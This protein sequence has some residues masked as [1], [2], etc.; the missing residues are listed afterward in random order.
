MYLSLDNI[1]VFN[2]EKRKN[3]QLPVQ[4]TEGS[5]NKGIIT[6]KSNLN[7]EQALED[8]DGFD[9]I[10][11]IFWFHENTTWR[12]KVLPPRY[13]KKI[14]VFATRSPHRP[15]PIGMSCVKLSKIE[16]RTLFIEDHDL[17]DG[18]P[19]Y[20]IKPYIA[21][22]DSHPDASCGWLKDV[23]NKL[24]IEVS[25]ECTE[26]ADW[27]KL[28]S[29]LDILAEVIAILKK[30]AY[31]SP[32]NRI[33]QVDKEKHVLAF[34]SWRVNYLFFEDITK[35]TILSIDS[36]Y[37]DNVTDAQKGDDYDLH[38]AYKNVEIIG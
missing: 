23:P 29:G 25:P 13:D 8:L 33:K 21:Y 2:T 7:Y 17:L 34:K 11:I 6:L 37:A 3:Y 36:G 15:N 28:N 14:G 19:I 22:A 1:G 10:W 12:P 18:T 27:I 32:S 16:G 30:K 5:G 9:R 26:S 20:D 38:Q 4:P 35:I 24:T 31:P